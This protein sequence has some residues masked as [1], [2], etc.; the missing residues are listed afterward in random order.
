[1]APKTL[2]E[3]ISS[4]T[5]RH[6]G[7]EDLIGQLSFLLD[8]GSPPFIFLQDAFA[9]GQTRK[10]LQ[11]VIISVADM[12]QESSII[13][14][15]V[16]CVECYTAK[17]LYENVLSSFT[18]FME[19]HRNADMQHIFDGPNSLKTF[20]DFLMMLQDISKVSRTQTG[21]TSSSKFEFWKLYSNSN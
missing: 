11:D 9:I 15:F 12:N 13:P 3:T 8:A 14:S 2:Q 16:D 5:K 4:L 6:P 17:I 19:H 10:V 18:L 7:Y 21:K 20:D 1:M